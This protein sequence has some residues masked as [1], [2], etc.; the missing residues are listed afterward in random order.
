MTSISQLILGCHSIAS[1]PS[2][3]QALGLLKSAWNLGVRHF[4]TAPI[5]S[6][7]YSEALLGQAFHGL[8]DAKITTKAGLYSIP[9]LI[10]P[11]GLAMRLNALR[12]LVQRPVSSLPS[13]SSEFSDEPNDFSPSNQLI[14]SLARLQRT[15]VD[16]L[17]LHEIFPW[18]CPPAL[19]DQLCAL[20]SNRLVSRLGYGGEY[21]NNFLEQSLPPWINVM[22]IPFPREECLLRQLCEWI[23]RHSEIEVR[24]FGLF[25]HDNPDCRAERL[26]LA[27]ALLQ[28]YPNLRLLFSCRSQHRLEANLRILLG[29]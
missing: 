12:S 9:S 5:Y 20:V 21:S 25:R 17:L 16:V 6:Q 10:L 13:A 22:Q 24:L 7:G 1:L 14:A 15:D 11:V 28:Q 4:D 2:R 23:E 27:S 19:I 18:M 8:D 3:R 26:K 29:S